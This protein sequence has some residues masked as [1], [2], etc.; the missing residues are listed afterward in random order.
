MS[1]ALTPGDVIS[2]VTTGAA[3]SVDYHAT[4]V[5]KLIA[6]TSPSSVKLVPTSGNVAAAG[7]QQ[8]TTTVAAL[9]EAMVK[10]I[11]FVNLPASG[12]ITLKVTLTPSGGAARALTPVVSLAIGDKLEFIAGMGWQKYDSTMRVYS[13]VVLP[14][15]RTILTA[16]TA[17]TYT[18]PSGCR[19]IDVEGWGPGGGGAGA[20]NAAASASVGGGGSSGG[21]FRKLIA[22][23]AATYVYTVGGKGTG[24]VS[25]ANGGNGAADTTFGALT[26][27]A[28][29]GGVFQAAAA[30]ALLTLGGDK[31]V[32]STGGDINGTGTPGG[33]SNRVNAT[34]A[35]SGI[36]GAT[37][38]GGAG[39]GRITQG[40]GS[41]ANANTGSGGGGAASINAGGVATGGDGADG[42]IVV[43][44]HY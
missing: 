18:T 7:T 26:A 6:E 16:G 4:Q 27:K 29:L 9:H 31:P 40:A 11:S 32:L 1:I 22:P 44:E 17:Q 34:I 20:A 28:G 33:V 14:A 19:A 38:L 23:P 42:L 41:S 10:A 13:T 8:V 35:V 25:G 36:G 3:V 30:T 15:T 12:A 5:D 21:Y 37:S 43:T 39:N 24:G 2:F